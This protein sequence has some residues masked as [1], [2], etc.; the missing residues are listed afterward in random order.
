MYQ[1]NKKIVYFLIFEIIIYVF[2]ILTKINKTDV[3]KVNSGLYGEA[4][5]AGKWLTYKLERRLK[6]IP[7]QIHNKRTRYVVRGYIGNEQI[8]RY[9]FC[10]LNKNQYSERNTSEICQIR[11][12]I[13]L[14]NSNIKGVIEKHIIKKVL[15]KNLNR[16]NS[17]SYIYTLPEIY[18]QIRKLYK[19]YKKCKSLSELPKLFGVPI[20]LKDNIITK[21]VL[22]K[23]GSKILSNYMGSYDSTVV[24]KLK[25][26][27]AI[28]IGKTH[29]DE[30]AMG[31]CTSQVKN[32][33]NEKFLSCGGSSG[34]SASCIGSKIMNCSLNTDTGGS[35]RIPAALCG[36]IGLKPTYGLISRYG[37]IP[38]N[39]ETDVIG[40]IVNNVY[41]CSI[42]LDVLTGKDKN[43]LT[44]LD[45]K[46]KKKKKKSADTE[47]K[48]NNNIHFLL[49]KY[50]RSEQFKSKYPLKNFKFSYLSDKLLKTYFVDRVVYKNYEKVKTHIKQMGGQLVNI[51]INNLIFYCYFYY[52]H[53]MTVVNSNLSRINGINYGMYTTMH[54]DDKYDG[55]IQSDM[56]KCIT[57]QIRTD[58]FGE[59]VLTRLIG[60]SIISSHFYKIN[61]HDIFLIIKKKLDT[62]LQHIFSKVDYIM[63]PSIP[64]SNNLNELFEKNS[65]FEK[66]NTPIFNTKLGINYNKTD[67][68][69][70][71]NNYTHIKKNNPNKKKYN[72][73]MKEVFTILASIT[74]YP[75]I[76][77][78]TGE[79]TKKMNEPKS[80]QLVTS[81]LNE[82]GLLKVA[83]AYKQKK[84]V[85]FKISQ[86]LKCV[87]TGTR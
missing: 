5:E 17:F 57:S 72:K 51:D 40:L 34:G 65:N 53:S 77:I 24:K 41:D 64:K 81:K 35:S 54:E 39:D 11:K 67:D 3:I 4:I 56:N 29:L 2:P 8:N 68:H 71:N 76:V 50:E 25:K 49:K 22:T 42:L 21:N 44:S 84:S 32:P 45:T 15:D 16:Y 37:I 87:K 9:T 26:N 66:I 20:I 79:F 38:Y 61:L 23:G 12:D 73:Y 82:L 85:N 62:Q 55:N 18:E 13:L 7:E 69:A 27:G 70:Y 6:K 46:K 48:K 19:I 58:L 31:S 14:S 59:Q 47:K 43:D 74:G 33:F 10:L 86:A 52:V 83:L 75:S 63:L 60:G 30:F 80:F 28:I 36:C 78:P 1:L